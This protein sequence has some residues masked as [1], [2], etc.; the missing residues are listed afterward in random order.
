M[1]MN[2]SFEHLQLHIES[3]ICTITLNR[4][5][6][7]ALSTELVAELQRCCEIV[8]NENSL[9][10]LILTNSG[11]IFSAG[12]DLKERKEMNDAEVRQFLVNIRDCFFKWYS[13]KIPTICA[14]KGGAFGG[15]LELALMCD[16]RYL[17]ENAQVGFP[18][19][20]LAIIPGAG[21]TQRLPRLIGETKAL[22]WILTGKR[23]SARDALKAG[24]VS[25]IAER[26]S[27]LETSME[28]AEKIREAAPIAVVQAK[29][30]VKD[31]LK[32]DYSSALRFETECY[33]VTIP[34]QD[35]K[36][37]LDAFAEK[38]SPEWKGE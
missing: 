37:A 1:N 8:Q 3:Q 22:E 28:L 34:T 12:A 13:M 35:R 14:M 24:V 16:F 26:E 15:G 27:V 38:R 7:N 21:G 32:L 30:A 25:E 29:Q 6:V 33:N 9:R 10:C 20:R 19:T 36:E 18:E 4:P 31:G 2:H 11:D 23:F 5:P 17:E